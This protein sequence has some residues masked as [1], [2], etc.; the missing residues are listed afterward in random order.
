VLREVFGRRNLLPHA[1]IRGDAD[2]NAAV[3]ISDAIVTFGFLFL[4]GDEGTCP[5]A[6]DADDSGAIDLSDGIT[7]LQHLF[8][9]GAPPAVPYPGCGWDLTVRDGIGCWETPC[10]YYP[11]T[12]LH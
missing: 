5:D 10:K 11:K 1:F 2:S 7:T 9:G 6:M 8:L 4:G 3:D 12:S